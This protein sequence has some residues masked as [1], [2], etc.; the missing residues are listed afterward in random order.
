M[1]PKI[2]KIG[3][4]LAI[5]W[6]FVGISCLKFCNVSRVVTKHVKGRKA[7]DGK[8]KEARNENIG[9]RRKEARNVKQGSKVNKF[10]KQM[11]Y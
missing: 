11:T 7:K 5:F 1:R 2:V 10:T 6:P 4:E 3:V 8:G 9:T